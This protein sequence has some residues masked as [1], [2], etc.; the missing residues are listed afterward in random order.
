MMK[1]KIL[2]QCTHIYGTGLSLRL[3][4]GREAPRLS[5]LRLVVSPA[6]NN[7][8]RMQ[9]FN[10]VVEHNVTLGL[11]IVYKACD[12]ALRMYTSAEKYSYI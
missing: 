6:H 2:I 9:G 1:E 3:T 5:T 11:L 4:S 10:V 8:R 7:G 12:S